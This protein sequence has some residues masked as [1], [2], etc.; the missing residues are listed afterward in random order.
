[1]AQTQKTKEIL[2]WK[3]KHSSLENILKT[4]WAWHQNYFSKKN[5]AIKI[6]YREDTKE[7]K[8]FI[9]DYRK[10][11]KIFASETI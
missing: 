7:F 11:E 5:Y 6:F 4:S 1:V 10:N 2:Q 3:P 8:R 9:L